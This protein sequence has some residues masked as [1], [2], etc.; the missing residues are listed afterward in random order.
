MLRSH[1][2]VEGKFSVYIKV[3]IVLF[4][5]KI[6]TVFFTE[7]EKKKTLKIHTGTE[8]TAKVIPGKKEYWHYSTQLQTLLRSH[9]NKDSMVLYRHGHVDQWSI[10]K[11]PDINLH[12]HGCLDFDKG[13][14]KSFC[15]DLILT[16]RKMRLGLHLSSC[17]KINS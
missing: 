9:S 6:P 16:L 4:S 8:K 2:D 5:I 17:T 11:D 14:N 3:S 10:I 1:W 13:V 15:R 7:L 12:S